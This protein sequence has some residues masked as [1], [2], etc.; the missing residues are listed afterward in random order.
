MS[1]R[2]SSLKHLP[3]RHPCSL[4]FLQGHVGHVWVL[5]RTWCRCV[6]TDRFSCSLLGPATWWQRCS[7]FTCTSSMEQPLLSCCQL[8]TLDWYVMCAISHSVSLSHYLSRAG[9]TERFD[10]AHG[11]QT[12]RFAVIR[13]VSLF[14][15]KYRTLWRSSGW[16]LVWKTWKGQGMWQL[17]GKC[18]GFYWK[19][20]KKSCQ[21]K[22]A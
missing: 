19:S 7:A 11:D 2:H 13:S 20:G 4:D 14:H 15:W 6:V 12:G 3:A 5:V 16:P 17:S 22:V 10:V 18:R 9:S 21:G 8:S 1:V